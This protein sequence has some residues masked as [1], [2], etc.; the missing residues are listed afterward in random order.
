MQFKSILTCASILVVT[1]SS[2]ALTTTWEG[3]WSG[4]W[5]EPRNWNNGVPGAGDTAVIPNVSSPNVDPVLTTTTSIAALNVQNGGAL[6]LN[7][8]NLTVSGASGFDIDAGGLVYVLSNGVVNITGSGTSPIDG[9]FDVEGDV[10]VTGGPTL[11]INGNVFLAASTT[12]FNI[13]TSSATFSGSGQVVG[14]HN[15][16]ALTIASTLTLTNQV[17]IVGRMTISGPGTLDND[18]FVI[19][20]SASGILALAS[21][22]ILSSGSTGDWQATVSGATLQFNRAHTGGSTMG[23]DFLIDNCATMQFN[24]V[25]VHTYD[26][27]TGTAGYLIQGV[28]SGSFQYNCASS[29]TPVTVPSTFG[30]CP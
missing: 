12:S 19:A 24:N 11:T 6:T 18:D 15:S 8:G 21:D 13:Q 23:G 1:A 4:S 14:E 7:G 5:T 26:S 28:S 27:F 30:G 2:Q 29:C 16:A 10:F 22:L 25:A 3:D 17:D 20:N 9:T